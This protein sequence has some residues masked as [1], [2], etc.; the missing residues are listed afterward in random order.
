MK[1]LAG[2]LQSVF[3]SAFLKLMREKTLAY[4][5]IKKKKQKGK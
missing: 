4:K 2:E 1:T 3:L 5:Q